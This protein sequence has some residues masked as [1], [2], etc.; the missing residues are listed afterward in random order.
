MTVLEMPRF[1]PERPPNEDEFYELV[2]SLDVAPIAFKHFPNG[3]FIYAC[4]D[5]HDSRFAIILHKTMREDF[6]VK[7]ITEKRAHHCLGFNLMIKAPAEGQKT[8]DEVRGWI[9]KA[10]VILEEENRG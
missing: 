6:Y 3:Y 7:M 4:D 1:K 10:R 2:Y 9:E 8:L 5:A